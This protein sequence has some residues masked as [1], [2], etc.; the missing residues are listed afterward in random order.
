MPATI[1][2]GFKVATVNVN[3]PS[4]ATIVE[5]SNVV[6]VPGVRANDILLSV[7]PWGV[8][9]DRYILKRAAITAADTVTLEWVN[10]SIATIDPAA[11][12]M[13][14]VWLRKPSVE[15]GFPAALG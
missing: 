6:T 10:E 7:S 9:E 1:T 5:G 2:Y 14:F 15:V 3:P 8:A 12:D 13:T 11:L 4:L